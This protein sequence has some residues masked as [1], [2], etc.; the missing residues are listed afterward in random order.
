LKTPIGISAG[1]SGHFSAAYLY[2]AVF[3]KQNAST[4]NL[5]NWFAIYSPAVRSV[6]AA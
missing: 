5:F 1:L 4:A 3:L 6:L 2:E